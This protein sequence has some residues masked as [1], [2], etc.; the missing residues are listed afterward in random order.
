MPKEAVFQDLTQVRYLGDNIF[1]LNEEV[2]QEKLCYK[3]VMSSTVNPF[4]FAGI[5]VRV[6][7]PATY[8]REL[9]FTVQL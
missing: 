3:A 5:N 4:K 1:V 2:F 8:S 9:K 6:L 7:V